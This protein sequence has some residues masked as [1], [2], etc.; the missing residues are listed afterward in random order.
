MAGSGEQ[1]LVNGDGFVKIQVVAKPGSARRG[2]LRRDPRG[3]LIGL[4]SQPSKGHANEEL[5][6]FLAELMGTAPSEVTIIRGQAARVKTLR[7]LNPSSARV[8]ALLRQYP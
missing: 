2:I 5:I 3:L 6:A 8:D 7:I 1:W 4:H